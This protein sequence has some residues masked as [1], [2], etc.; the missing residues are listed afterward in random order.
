VSVTKIRE[1]LTER[2]SFEK[3]I[4]GVNSLLLVESPGT[5]RSES[6]ENSGKPNFQ[7]ITFQRDQEEKT[8]DDIKDQEYSEMRKKERRPGGH[9]KRNKA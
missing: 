7:P 4:S 8:K 6:R 1:T 9:I 5:R 2:D 3:R